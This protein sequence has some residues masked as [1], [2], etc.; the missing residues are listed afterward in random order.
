MKFLL[1]DP[2]LDI[3]IKEIKKNIRLSMNGVVADHLQ[4][5]GLQYKQNLGVTITRLKEIASAYQP[6]F[7]LAK[8]LW[9]LG[10]RE[11]M[12]MATFLMPKDKI[13]LK[14][15]DIWMESCSNIELAEQLSMNLFSKCDIMNDIV[16]ELLKSTD[17]IYLSTAYLTIARAYLS[18]SEENIQLAMNKAIDLSSSDDFQ[19]IRTIGVAMGRTCRLSKEKA[20]SV[21]SAF[22]YHSKQNSTQGLQSIID[23]IRQEMIFLG[24]I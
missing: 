22:N 8:R 9:L 2:Q 24:F 3:Q 18:I 7:D 19:L 20:G 13:D 16:S 17:V 6:D 5:N 1:S 4:Q 21:L 15:V 14:T 23:S 10:H 11:T 12:I